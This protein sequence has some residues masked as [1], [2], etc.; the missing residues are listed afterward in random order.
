MTVWK[1]MRVRREKKFL[2]PAAIWFYLF[3]GMNTE[4]KRTQQLAVFS[5]EFILSLTVNVL[6]LFQNNI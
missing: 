1:E 5:K 4:V 6:R 3:V 2:W